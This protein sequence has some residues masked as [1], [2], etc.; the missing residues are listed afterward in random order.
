M[1]TQILSHLP[2]GFPWGETIQCFDT[3]DSTNTLAK[4]LAVQGAPEGTVLLSEQQTGGRG[5]LGRSFASP[6]MGIYL[7]VILRPSCPPAQLMHLTCAAAVAM[8]DA[9][10]AAVGIRPRIKWINDLVYG[11]RKLAGILTE[12]GLDSQTYLVDYAVI[13][14]G[15]NCC[16]QPSDFPPELRDVAGSLAMA[17]ETEI[18]RAKVA[19]A[20]VQA[21]YQ[22]NQGLLLDKAETMNQYRRDCLTLG[23]QISVIR[24][25]SIRKGLAL[26]ID[27][28]GGLLV[29]YTDGTRETVASGEVSVRGLYGYV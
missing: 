29:R 14:I 13:G 23:Q 3:V 20:M 26:D 12:L 22:M 5:R 8:C 24:G 2:Q 7:S 1:K 19:A 11:N 18:D 25:D 6:G 27:G 17:A 16:Q 21:L 10:A 28:D 15:L 9:V 4:K